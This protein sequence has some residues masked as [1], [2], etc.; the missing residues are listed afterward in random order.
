MP[1]PLSAANT[2]ADTPSEENILTD[3]PAAAGKSI[4]ASNNGTNAV[5]IYSQRL[6]D[7]LS[8]ATIRLP[9]N[10]VGVRRVRPDAVPKS[11]GTCETDCDATPKSVLSNAVFKTTGVDGVERRMTRQE[12]KEYK[13]KLALQQKE[14]KKQKR[15]QDRIQQ[16]Q[17]QQGKQHEQPVSP[18][19]RN[20]PGNH[21]NSSNNSEEEVKYL[22]ANGLSEDSRLPEL[23]TI[24]HSQK[25]EE[26]AATSTPSLEKNNYHALQINPSLL[27]QETNDL[28][29]DRHRLPPVVLPS[30]MACLAAT[31]LRPGPEPPV[32]ASTISE[33]KDGSCFVGADEH[34]SS[35]GA[36]SHDNESNYINSLLVMKA[37]TAKPLSAI[38][39][40]DHQLSVDWAKMLKASMT[41]AETIRNDEDMRPMAY[42]LTPEPWTRYRY[43]NYSN[44]NEVKH[45]KS[46]LSRSHE[47]GK[48][49]GDVV[50]DG[51]EYDKELQQREKDKQDSQFVTNLRQEEQASVIL[52]SQEDKIQLREAITKNRNH[53]SKRAVSITATGSSNQFIPLSRDW[54]HVTIRPASSLLSSSASAAKLDSDH[55]IVME[56]LHSRTKFF[57]SCG[58]KFGCDL[59]L[60]DG[61]RHERHSF[62]GLR[63]LTT[64]GCIADSMGKDIPGLGVPANVPGLQPRV[65]QLPI[66]TPYSMSGY[67]R[68]LNTAGKLALVATVVR[69]LVPP[70]SATS[71]SINSMKRASSTNGKSPVIKDCSSS[72]LMH[73][74]NRLDAGTAVIYRV[75]IVDLALEKVLSAPTHQRRMHHSNKSAATQSRR[76]EIGRHLAKH[77]NTIK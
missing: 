21:S 38:I 6:A 71:A 24:C 62:A 2:L 65:D 67:V 8:S 13:R 73:V 72:E 50:S 29:N 18:P 58:A 25:K 27:E 36:S 7:E 45:T 66:P 53:V 70:H 33:Q 9:P 52:E 64:S 40:Y 4:G 43:N 42:Q 34:S 68:G 39:K 61:P 47:D 32:T 3:I 49:N 48:T 55:S 59:L 41:L 46:S 44:I 22:E 17:E 19:K 20:L 14:A 31:I 1:E 28:Q 11:I 15:E 77:G 74:E 37:N 35:H 56:Y 54:S 69:E 75:A 23:S 5:I 10:Y 63:I 12:K 76:K 57:V 30:S 51:N 26:R 16:R 60:Y